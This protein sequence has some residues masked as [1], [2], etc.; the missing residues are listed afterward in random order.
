MA[1]HRDSSA[2]EG[3]FDY[4]EGTEL[5]NKDWLIMAVFSPNSVSQQ[6]KEYSSN[7][8]NE[9]VDEVLYEGQIENK[10]CEGF[11]DF[12]PDMTDE[13]TDEARYEAGFGNNRYE[14]V[15]ALPFSQLSHSPM[16]DGFKDSF[17]KIDVPNRDKDECGCSICLENYRNKDDCGCS[18]CLEFYRDKD[19]CG[20]SICVEYFRGKDN[21]F[22]P[23]DASLDAATFS[24]SSS[25]V[26]FSELKEVEG[27]VEREVVPEHT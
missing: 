25:F 13:E 27:H 2:S 26:P 22:L 21:G 6:S 1:V 23:T 14:K 12:L 11:D 5:F 17:P 8:T 10:I 4:A 7:M 3:I 19:D 24:S 18:F 9:A 15:P 20:C 16:L